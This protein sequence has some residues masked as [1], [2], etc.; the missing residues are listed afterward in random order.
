MKT[1][2]S[3]FEN[4]YFIIFLFGLL[5]LIAVLT[6]RHCDERMNASMERRCAILKEISDRE[7]HSINISEFVNDIYTDKEMLEF[8]RHN[9]YV[10]QIDYGTD[11][12][13]NKYFLKKTDPTSITVYDLQ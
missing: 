5:S 8:A 12:D 9:G 2:D 3:L 11:G 6:I 10:V 7:V 4:K 1:L 13:E